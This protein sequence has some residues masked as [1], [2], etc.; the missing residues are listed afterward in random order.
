MENPPIAASSHA[1]PADGRQSRLLFFR[2]MLSFATRLRAADDS[3]QAMR[4]VTTHICALFECSWFALYAVSDDQA[5]IFPRHHTGAATASEL[6]LAVSD[7]SVAGYVALHRRPLCIR[8]VYDDDELAAHAPELRFSRELDA[9]TGQRTRQMLV[10]PLVDAHGLLGVLQLVNHRS[11]KAFRSIAAEA[12]REVGAA[13]AMS[14][15]RC[16]P[17]PS[18]PRSKYDFL[19]RDDVLSAAE[20]ARARSAADAAGADLEQILVDEYRVRLPLLGAA[21]AKFYG[22]PY[23]PFRADRLKPGGLLKNLKREFVEHNRWLLIDHQQDVLVILA[24]DPDQVRQARMVNQLFPKAR[25]VFRVTTNVEFKLTVDSFFGGLAD[26]GT[27]DALLSGMQE[28]DD[29]AT[30]AP[31]DAG[32]VDDDELVRLVNTIIVD[33]Y[34]Q[35]ASDIHIEP[36]TGADKTLVRFR[37]DGSLEPYAEVPASY[38]SK[39]LARIKIMCDLD[40]SEHRKPQDG[41]INFLK[42]APLDIELRVL[43]IP[44]AGA[45][46]DVVM[47]ILSAGE[48][49]AL[50]Q[51]GVLPQNLRRLKQVI[52]NP[53]GLF[54]VCGPTGSGKTTTLHS[55]LHALN[56]PEA[57]IWTAEDPVEITQKGL[58]QVQ[59]N[60]KTGFDFA[61]VMR[62]F[63]RAD[64][65]IIM[66]GEM[67]DKETVSICLEASLTGHLV[68]ATLHTNSAAES[69]VRLLDMGMEPFTCADA[70]LGVL[71]QRLTKR[72]CLNCRRPY[73]ATEQEVDALLTEYCAE[74]RPAP[75]SGEQTAARKAQVRAMWSERH[76]DGAGNFTLYQPVG[77]SQC[78]RGYKGRIGLHELMV[79]TDRIKQLVQERARLAELVGAAQGDGMLTLK[80]DGIEKVLYGATDMKHVRVVC[81]N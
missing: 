45:V 22:V 14:L 6:T 52:A 36:G 65:D 18:A 53:H 27:V 21:L 29:E 1:P 24:P 42:Y 57:K 80:M 8:D 51:L 69:I 30:Q 2:R 73:R 44:T 16:Q 50:E 59:V 15:R 13:L 71:A 79:A 47:R 41:K 33:A 78:T 49:I 70:L 74:L 10:A 81:I 58:R 60:R 26:G 55:V 11:G 20:L 12:L 54:F 76:A 67:R 19:I 38:R 66:V 62:S 61:T 35:G 56:T 9:R 37:K 46:E 23:E 3:E 68:L 17:P 32:S 39:L 77:C 7:H 25:L 31:V 4:D 72:L 34:R 40:I 63:L 64:P 48:P 28:Q 75:S 5:T 43:T